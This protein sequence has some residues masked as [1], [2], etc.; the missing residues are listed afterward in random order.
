[1]FQQLF[2]EMG[3]GNTTGAYRAN[4]LMEDL[5]PR[6]YSEFPRDIYENEVQ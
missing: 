4:T 5:G 6:T 2:I 1:M 3:S